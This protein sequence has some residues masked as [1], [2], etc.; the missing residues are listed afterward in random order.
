MS[1]TSASEFTA[2]FDMGG[3]LILQARPATPT[4]SVPMTVTRAPRRAKPTV[5]VLALL[6]AVALFLGL[7][8]AGLE[9]S[10]AIAPLRGDGPPTAY[11]GVPV[12]YD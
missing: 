5:M 8:I 9:Y 7:V 2:Y 12:D 11:H 1:T 10:Y 4:L 6:L 3:K